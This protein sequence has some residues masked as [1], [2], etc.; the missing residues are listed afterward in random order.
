MKTAHCNTTGLLGYLGEGIQESGRRS[1]GL[2]VG[3]LDG[4]FEAERQV[5]GHEEAERQTESSQAVK[6]HRPPTNQPTSLE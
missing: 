4:K 1:L 3:D 5:A 2:G 6:A